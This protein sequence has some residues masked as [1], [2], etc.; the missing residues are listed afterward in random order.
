MAPGTEGTA[1]AGN[2][3]GGSI[4]LFTNLKGFLSTWSLLGTPL[5]PAIY[6]RRKIIVIHSLDK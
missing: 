1:T 6:Q 4:H 5:T 2:D 3:H